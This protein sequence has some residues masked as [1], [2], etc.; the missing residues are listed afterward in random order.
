M[1]L[2]QIG[3]INNGGR[4]TEQIT[5]GGWFGSWTWQ[6]TISQDVSANCTLQEGIVS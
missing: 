1:Q 4:Y 6:A 5:R 3:Q 2:Y